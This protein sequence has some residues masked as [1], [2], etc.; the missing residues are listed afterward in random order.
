MT[1]NHKTKRPNTILITSV[2]VTVALLIALIY[3]LAERTKWNNTTI[4]LQKELNKQKQTIADLV[5]LQNLDNSVFSGQDEPSLQ[6]YSNLLQDSN[7]TVDRSHI[8]NRIAYLTNSYKSHPDLRETIKEARPHQLVTTEMSP[9]I[10][11]DRIQAD[12]SISDSLANKITE[13]NRKI[14]TRERALEEK[15]NLKAITIQST[16]GSVIQYVGDT[17]NGMANGEGTGLWQSSGG[18]YKGSWQDNKRHGHGI[19]TWKDGVRYEGNY[20]RDLREGKGVYYWPTGERYEGQ[21][22]SNRR[23]G[24]GT[25]YDKDGNITY[26]GNWINDKPKKK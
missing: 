25:L 17:K 18:T 22:K 7:F 6:S 20:V 8:E 1:S 19:Y 4:S 9:T 14:T 13:L 12:T 2:A 5:I 3:L 26:Q 23:N 10:H 16:D 24:I 11:L 15:E 21:W